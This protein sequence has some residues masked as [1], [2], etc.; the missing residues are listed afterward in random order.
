MLATIGLSSKNDLHSLQLLT[1]FPRASCSLKPAH[2]FSV[3][4]PPGDAPSAESLQFARSFCCLLSLRVDAEQFWGHSD[5][6]AEGALKVPERKEDRI[7]E[8]RR[9]LVPVE[10]QGC[11]VNSPAGY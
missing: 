5:F 9:A 8:I 6:E 10:L 4:L 7:L 11:V 3:G 2:V 1:W